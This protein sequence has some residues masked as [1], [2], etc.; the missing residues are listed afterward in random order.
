M[1]SPLDVLGTPIIDEPFDHRHWFEW[2]DEAWWTR[3]VRNSLRHQTR[4][5]ERNPGD[6]NNIVFGLKRN[7]DFTGWYPLDVTWYELLGSTAL[8]AHGWYWN[9]D[10]KVD[11]N[12]FQRVM[13]LLSTVPATMGVSGIPG[14][15]C[16]QLWIRGSGIRDG[17][18][19]PAGAYSR[20]EKSWKQFA[21]D[22]RIR[23]LRSDVQL[24]HQVIW[25]PWSG[26]Q[27]CEKELQAVDLSA[28]V[29]MVRIKQ[30]ALNPVPNDGRL[31]R[32]HLHRIEIFSD[33]QRGTVTLRCDRR[34]VLC[35]EARQCVAQRD[36]LM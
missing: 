21:P 24:S 35:N 25:P 13:P 23:H 4:D 28:G 20:Y 22:I 27:Y 14:I 16:N 36:I 3:R 19:I 31:W 9:P 5:A 11:Y 30:S 8:R 17:S 26:M 18:E 15:T 34:S 6:P 1:C 7:V 32:P 33:T 12:A 2:R 10:A 29:A